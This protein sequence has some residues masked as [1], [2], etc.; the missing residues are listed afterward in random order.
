[1][2]NPFN[3]PILLAS[4]VCG[5]SMDRLDGQAGDLGL[6]LYRGSSFDAHQWITLWRRDSYTNPSSMRATMEARVLAPTWLIDTGE[7]LYVEWFGTMI[8]P[9]AAAVLNYRVDLFVYG[10]LQ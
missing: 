10:T 2:I 9:C 8:G 7:S 5:L 1:M 6:N 4:A 3:R